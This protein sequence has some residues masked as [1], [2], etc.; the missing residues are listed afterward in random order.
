MCVCGSVDFET[1]PPARDQ[2]RHEI[3]HALLATESLDHDLMFGST[4]QAIKLFPKHPRW[5]EACGKDVDTLPS[6]RI[7]DGLAHALHNCPTFTPMRVCK[8]RRAT[9]RQ[10]FQDPAGWAKPGARTARIRRDCCSCEIHAS[11][12]IALRGLTTHTFHLAQSVESGSIEFR[13][14]VL[15]RTP[16]N[17]LDVVALGKRCEASRS[18]EHPTASSCQ[19]SAMVVVMSIPLCGGKSSSRKGQQ[20]SRVAR[21]IPFALLLSRPFAPTPPSPPSASARPLCAP[22][23][24]R[25][26]AAPRSR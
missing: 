10:T 5:P 12:H 23:G 6:V 9:Q 20:L 25:I 2:H 15:G 17:P 24:F 21:R 18:A 4:T 1:T 14:L 11:M 13:V 26:P 8:R 7:A 22:A 3:Q 16:L 19:C